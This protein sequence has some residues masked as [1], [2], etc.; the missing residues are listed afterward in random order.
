MCAVMTDPVTG[1][2]ECSDP[3]IYAAMARKMDPDN[4]RYHEAMS[5]P[6]SELF[7][8][9]MV[10]EVTALTKKNTWTLVPR[11]SVINHKVLP[12]TW[13]FK[14][15]LL[16]FSRWLCSQMQSTVLCTRGST[17]GRY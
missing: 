5:G 16:A 4:P 1:L 9:A 2:L 10:T 6:D 11:S 14:R 13:A 17:A 7:R 3:L 8:E 12:G 15:K